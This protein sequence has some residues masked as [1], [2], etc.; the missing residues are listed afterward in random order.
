MATPSE[1]LASLIGEQLV[2]EK[3][4][5]EDDARRLLGTL[6]A[7]TLTAEDWRFEL[8]RAEPEVKK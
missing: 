5:R 4:I 8:E 1:D 6:A 7:G 2:R 3:I